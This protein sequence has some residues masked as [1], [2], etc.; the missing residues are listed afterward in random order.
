VQLAVRTI[1]ALLVTAAPVPTSIDA[2]NTRSGFSGG[3]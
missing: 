2:V 1:P 3:Q